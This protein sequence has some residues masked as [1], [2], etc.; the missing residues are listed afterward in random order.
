MCSEETQWNVEVYFFSRSRKNLIATVCCAGRYKC[1]GH[2]KRNRALKGGCNSNQRPDQKQPSYAFSPSTGR[3][4]TKCGQSMRCNYLPTDLTS[5]S[6]TASPGPQ[7]EEGEEVGPWAPLRRLSICNRRVEFS[8]SRSVARVL[9]E[10][11]SVSKCK[12]L[13]LAACLALKATSRLRMT[14]AVFLSIAAGS[15]LVAEGLLED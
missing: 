6:K 10:V 12:S 4:C 11:F 13:S 14:L 7:W 15:E 8:I 2:K 5:P 9:R 3:N 1:I